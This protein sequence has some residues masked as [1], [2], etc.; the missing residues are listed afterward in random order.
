MPKIS[1][2]SK[3]V[4]KIELIIFY[5]WQSDLNNKTNKFFIRD[6]I[7]QCIK[8]IQSSYSNEINLEI[9]IDS[10]TK[11]T[12][13]TPDIDKII[14]EKISNSDIFIADVSI[15]N[16]LS[17][18][19][20]TPNPNVLFELGYAIS[21]IG[22]ENVI[23]VFNTA[24][25][26]PEDLPFDL[27]NKRMMVYQ[28]KNENIFQRRL[29][30]EYKRNLHDQL[31]SAIKK[32]LSGF[33]SNKRKPKKLEYPE[34]HRKHDFGIYQKILKLLPPNGAIEF[35]RDN[36][37]AGFPF[38]WSSMQDLKNIMSI[39]RDPLIEFIDVELELIKKELFDLIENLLR[40]LGLNT[41]YLKG[42]MDLATVPN[43]W[44]LDQTDRFNNVV[45]QIHELSSLICSN[46]DI[47]IRECRKKLL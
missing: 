2:N 1:D 34:S 19:R 3:K 25:G 37:F 4:K 30:N 10:D 29:V 17:K 33:D 44:E 20:K 22:W 6:C 11:N 27:R 8:E 9:R 18:E 38:R 46:Y 7:I 45:K 28:C 32:I 36:N 42:E 40:F 14:F 31:K 47:F 5:S 24:F 16:N 21:K 23:C 35:L 15:I 13:G 41:W 12:S 39:K 26:K 43:E